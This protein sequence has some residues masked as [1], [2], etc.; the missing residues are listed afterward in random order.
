M[1][2]VGTEPVS[3]TLATSGW[4]TRSGPVSRSPWM[5][6]NRPFGKPASM[7]IS[8]IFNAPSGVFS[9][10]LKTMALPAISAGAAF[11]QAICCG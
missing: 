10:G 5:T 11:Q 2:P 3:E 6:L 1:R 4:L 9:E 7:R 8:A